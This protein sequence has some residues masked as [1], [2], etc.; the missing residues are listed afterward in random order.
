MRAK[1]D[2]AFKNKLTWSGCLP[3]IFDSPPP[4]TLKTPVVS[5]MIVQ[6]H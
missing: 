3:Q 2:H 5:Y 4:I 6:D 1:G